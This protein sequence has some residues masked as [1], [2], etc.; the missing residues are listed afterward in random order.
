MRVIS[1]SRR[2]GIIT[3]PFGSDGKFKLKFNRGTRLTIGS[4]L[5]LRYKR[6]I[7]DKSKKIY[8]PEEPSDLDLPD[9]IP[10]DP[11]I[12]QIIPIK[13]KRNK[14]RSVTVSNLE[15]RQS[16]LNVISPSEMIETIKP[17]QFISVNEVNLP[18]I[19][20]ETPISSSI[21]LLEQI[22][23]NNVSDNGN[24]NANTFSTT[25]L[26]YEVRIGIVDSIKQESSGE[27][28][29]S[30]NLPLY[31][32]IVQGAFKMEENIRRFIGSEVLGAQGERGQLMGP[33]AKMGKCKVTFPNG[34]QSSVGS[35]VELH[36]VEI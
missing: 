25:A 34:F 27:M 7:F 5:V 13:S 32:V 31:Q 3:G 16:T 35:K 30:H 26:N 8:Q 33:Y 19:T 9:E 17:I 15:E 29:S 18:S 10:D 24:T 6:Y 1:D 20:P 21:Q 36:L 23:S 2:E 12:S 28:I 4:K 14:S 22:S 11:A